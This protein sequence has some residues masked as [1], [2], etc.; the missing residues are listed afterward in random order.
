MYESK[1][2]TSAA[3]FGHE[4]SKIEAH[5]ILR[6]VSGLSDKINRLLAGRE[7]PALPGDKGLGDL[8][9]YWSH[10]FGRDVETVLVE[11][12]SFFFGR[13]IDSQ[14]AVHSW[15]YALHTR[16]QELLT[17][18]MV[19]DGEFLDRADQ[20]ISQFSKLI[21]LHN[22]AEPRLTDSQ[23]F[24]RLSRLNTLFEAYADKDDPI[25]A[26]FVRTAAHGV[27][28]VVKYRS[29]EITE[30]CS[31]A[32]GI[33]STRLDCPSAG[34]NFDRDGHAS[35]LYLC[36][37]LMKIATLKAGMTPATADQLCSVVIAAY[38]IDPQA[39]TTDHPNE[40]NMRWFEEPDYG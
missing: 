1:T 15:M 30:E 2:P 36:N 27:V 20:A 10:L 18:G 6:E 39:L 17:Y 19:H 31:F 3:L 5:G 40:P 12:A 37:S 16:T 8:R 33:N 7:C 25:K 22:P 26:V 21:E 23:A 4:M 14:Q 28:T 24:A 38:Q 35:P 11:V 9:E 29:N 32:I 34:F 13:D